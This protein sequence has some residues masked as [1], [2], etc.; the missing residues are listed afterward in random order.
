MESQ[1]SITS[2]R[3]G[4]VPLTIMLKQSETGVPGQ[5]LKYSKCLKAKVSMINDV[6]PS[7]II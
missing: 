6:L 5:M 4:R 7:D 2:V 1:F 3:V